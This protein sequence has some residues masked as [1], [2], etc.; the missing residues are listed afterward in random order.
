MEE[1]R[2]RKGDGS[3][4][5]EKGERLVWSERTRVKQRPIGRG[6]GQLFTAADLQSLGFA[7]VTD[8]DE[9]DEMLEAAALSAESVHS[10]LLRLGLVGSHAGDS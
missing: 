9:E 10:T 7:D 6:E 3:D 4:R 2:R 5:E 8:D 1:Q